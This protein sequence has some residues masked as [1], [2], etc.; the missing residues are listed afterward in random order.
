VTGSAQGSDVILFATGRG[1]RLLTGV[2]ALTLASYVSF[3]V[4]PYVVN[5]L[6]LLPLAEVSSGR[7]DPKDLWPATIP[8]IG[9]WLHLFGVLS[10]VFAPMVLV[11]ALL[12]SGAAAVFAVRREPPVW[13][14]ATGYVL[15]ALSC[16]AG[17]AFA[18]GPTSQ[19]LLTWQMD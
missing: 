19:D 2:V 11:G 4:V 16:V 3:V 9:G 12:G 1:V 5:D 10:A 7:H 17:L 18:L 8:Y 14:V 6:H 13:G 15:V